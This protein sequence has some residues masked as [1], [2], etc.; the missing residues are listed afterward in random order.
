ME[1]HATLTIM[2][3]VSENKRDDDGLKHAEM[4]PGMSRLALDAVAGA[5]NVLR[6]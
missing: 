1:P 5:A 2:A 6:K 4:F 3:C